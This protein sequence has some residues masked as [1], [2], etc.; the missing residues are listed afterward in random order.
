MQLKIRAATVI[1]IALFSITACKR[2]DAPTPIANQVDNTAQV[3]AEAAAANPTQAEIDQYNKDEADM[4]ERGD[5]MA[6]DAAKPLLVRAV[7]G[8]TGNADNKYL[9]KFVD[10]NGD[11]VLDAVVLLQGMDFCGSGGCTMMVFEGGNDA[12]TFKS[13]STVSETP[14]R[15]AASKTNGWN[16]LIVSSDGKDRRMVFDGSKYPGNPSVLPQAAGEDVTSASVAIA[17]H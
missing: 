7:A 15:V 17:S 5:A 11:N 4:A 12:M 3:E 8:Q 1:A 14:I 2:D 16:D 9:E 10:L 6:T 13:K